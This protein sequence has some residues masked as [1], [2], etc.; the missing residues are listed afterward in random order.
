MKAFEHFETINSYPDAVDKHR[1]WLLD[2]ENLHYSISENG[3]DLI[4]WKQD[5]DKYIYFNKSYQT[6]INK[7]Q[8]HPRRLI[9]EFDDKIKGTDQKDKELIK[10]H[11]EQVKLQLKD[12]N[13]GFIESSHSG[14]SNYIWVEFNRNMTDQE[15]KKFLLYIAP[16]ESEIDLNF[17]SSNYRHPVLYAIH[18]KH[19]NFREMPVDYY[20]GE[21]INYDKLNIPKNIQTITKTKTLKNG[22]RYQTAEI[23]ETK[24]LKLRDFNYYRTLKKPRNELIETLIPRKHLVLIYAPP[25]NLKSLFCLDQCMCLASGRLFLN[26]FKTKKSA[27]LYIDLENNEQIIKDRWI[28]LRKFHRIRK[29]D[30][31]LYY[32]TRENHIDIQDEFFIAKLELIIEEKKIQ[33]IVVDT[34]PKAT[35]YNSKEEGEVNQLYMNFFAPLIE[36]Y[37]ISISFLLHTTKNSKS[38]LGSQ[39]YLGMCDLSYELKKKKGTTT[40]KILSD[41]R[42][43]NTNLGVEFEFLDDMITTKYLEFVEEEDETKLKKGFVSVSK[44][45][46]VTEQI[47]NYFPDSETILKRKEILIKLN[48]DIEFEVTNSLLTRVLNYLTEDI[49]FLKKTDKPGTYKKNIE[50]DNL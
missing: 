20:P 13:I 46:Q 45:K 22:F 41:N 28:K 5:K 24:E 19:S 21:Q 34:L 14:A 47:K 1:S 16:K 32:L 12:K 49:K 9:I 23:L 6:S 18:W 50:K 10:K 42:I 25:K 35:C 17:A 8:R 33:Y 44:L 40:I 26:K 2:Y 37:G 4:K 7:I 30:A 11:L 27:C 3:I 39:A 29:R 48:G 38:F 15:C 31:P 43:E 36:K